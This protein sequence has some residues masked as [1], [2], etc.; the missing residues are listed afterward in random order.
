M[1]PDH[2]NLSYILSGLGAARRQLGDLRG[3][4]EALRRATDIRRRSFGPGHLLTSRAEA[5]LGA[6]LRDQGKFQEAETLL[7]SVARLYSELEPPRV[8]EQ[9]R[10]AEHLVELYEAM[11]DETAAARHREVL[12][13]LRASSE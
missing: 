8:R 7:L 13:R 2:P 10:V 9:T 1:G 3:A 6:C 5:L 4:E 12:D 11:G